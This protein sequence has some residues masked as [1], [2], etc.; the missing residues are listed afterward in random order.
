MLMRRQLSKN[1]WLTCLCLLFALS[2]TSNALSDNV[3]LL[4]L[5][6]A[7]SPA[8]SQWIID[9]LQ[10]AQEEGA[11]LVVIRMDTPGGLD[12]S[13]RA[14]VKEILA[15]RIP[16]VTWVAP[17]G[18][19]AASAGTYILYASHIAAM[20]PATNLGAATP[21]PIGATLTLPSP[22]AND[23]P[24]EEEPANQEE[25]ASEPAKDTA[26]SRKIVND[27][28]AYIRGLAQLRGRNEEWAEIAVKEGKSLSAEEALAEGVIDIIAENLTS[29]LDQVEGISIRWNEADS[30][31]VLHL[32]GREI[33]RI[34][35]DWRHQFLAFITDPSVAYLFLMIGFWGLILEFYNPGIGLAGVAG[36][37]FLLLGLFAL[38]TLPINYAGLALI[39]LGLA[40]MIA[41]AMVPSF[42]V[43]GVGGV[44]A[45]VLG[46]VILMDTKLP[47]YQISITL[48]IGFALASALVFIGGGML[49]VK[50][51]RRRTATGTK[52]MIGTS[53]QVTADF[54]EGGLGKVRVLGEIWQARLAAGQRSPKIGDALTI[55][56]VDAL[57][58]GVIRDSSESEVNQ[59]EPERDQ[60]Q[61][62][63]TPPGSG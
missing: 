30:E 3:Y 9:N 36:A 39:V 11:E 29:L 59:S 44:V 43:F 49:V 26:M 24:P 35:P 2:G 4:E 37:I 1:R 60:A 50:A 17:G 21:V 45:F 42:G 51:H 22:I 63:E 27:A 55:T 41:E 52:A 62:S 16:V 54:N 28:A 40:L 10:L 34:V 18:S 47:G 15:S 31:R 5:S 14:I 19:R 32:T 53:A 12:K 13:M 61:D 20:A 46:S 6:G 48:I 38:Q 57:V 23:K 8:T 7:I 33:K 25:P 58:L 56:E